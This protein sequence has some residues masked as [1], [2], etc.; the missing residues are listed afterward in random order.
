MT[1]PSETKSCFGQLLS[2]IYTW[3]VCENNQKVRIDCLKARSKKN[4]FECKKCVC[5][6]FYML[7]YQNLSIYCPVCNV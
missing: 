5:T 2:E 1:T 7:D 6:E 3:W 4:K